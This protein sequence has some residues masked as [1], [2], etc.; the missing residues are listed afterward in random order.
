M[1]FFQS[2]PYNFKLVEISHD[3]KIT[4][5]EQNY[6]V[7]IF[8]EHEHNGFS[9]K[10]LVECKRHASSIKRE[11]IQVL[12][13]KIQETGS[14]KGILVSASDFQKGA[15]DY[16]K[17]KGIALV[18]ILNGEQTIE[19]RGHDTSPIDLKQYKKHFNI[20]EFCLRQ[21]TAGP[22]NTFGFIA[23]DDDY[24]GKILEFLFKDE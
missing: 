10:T 8:F 19:L 6:Q 17:Q 11:V 4:V 12:Y 1:K 16:A 20:P 14:N 23:L 7:D 15:M 2:N 9:Y 18:R 21:F 3:K 24:K 22:N 5:G 13:N